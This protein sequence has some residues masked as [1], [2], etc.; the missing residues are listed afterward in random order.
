MAGYTS[1]GDERHVND[2]K[3]EFK[4]AD[5]CTFNNVL[6]L[7]HNLYRVQPIAGLKRNSGSKGENLPAD[8]NGNVHGYELH[9]R[10]GQLMFD[11]FKIEGRT[12]KKVQVGEASVS[13]KSTINCSLEATKG[14]QRCWIQSLVQ[15]G[16]ISQ[17]IL[18]K[19][20]A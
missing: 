8:D 5:Q 13:P 7:V 20:G 3:P 12:W 9:I 14:Q 4:L 11:V 17:S 19:I 16:L 1:W 6:E 2:P 15:T 18:K 10:N